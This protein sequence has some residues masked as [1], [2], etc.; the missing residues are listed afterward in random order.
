MKRQRKFKQGFSN[1]GVALFFGACTLPFAC[2]AA[3]FTDRGY[4]KLKEG[5]ECLFPRKPK[6][7]ENSDDAKDGTS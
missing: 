5:F 1:L 2:V 7:L 6:Q 4:T 3:E